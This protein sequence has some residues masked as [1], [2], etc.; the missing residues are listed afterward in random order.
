MNPEDRR[1]LI[2]RLREMSI[3][4]ILTTEIKNGKI[5]FVLKK[6]GNFR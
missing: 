2:D 6:N 4:S 1:N 5:V 3:N